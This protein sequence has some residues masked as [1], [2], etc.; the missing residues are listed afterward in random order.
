MYG[1]IYLIK[2]DLERIEKSANFYTFFKRMIFPQGT[3]FRYTVWMRILANCKRSRI[4]KYT[5][6]LLAYIISNHYSIKYGIHINENIEIGPGLKIVHSDCVY[7][8]CKKIGSN[9]TV[10]Q[11]CTLGSANSDKGRALI[12]IVEDNVT[13]YTGSVVAGDVTLHDGCVI[14]AN[15]FVNFDVPENTL[16]SGVPAKIVRKVN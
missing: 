12:P 2:S 7:L 4:K 9:F 1:L 10:Y 8:N 5:I 16:V 3:T 14:G 6:G 11:G 13:V 15:S